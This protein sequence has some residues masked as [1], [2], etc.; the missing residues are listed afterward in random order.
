MD[1]QN[2]YRV[3]G[4]F[5][6]EGEMIEAVPYGNGHIND[7]YRITCRTKDGMRRY[8]LQKMNRNVFVRPE[9]LM[10]NV[11]GV[12]EW[13]R[14]KIT[15]QGGDALLETLNYVPTHDGAP[16]LKEA[17]GEY[18]RVVLFIENASCYDLVEKD[19]DF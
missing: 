19:E 10:E 7:T 17:D 12:T 5:S 18:W 11:C 16:Y 6:L 3:A 9:E 15:E 1:Q 4:Q 14:K 2:L 13:L 8:I